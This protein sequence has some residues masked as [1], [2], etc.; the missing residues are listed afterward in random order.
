MV[1]Q[2]DTIAF[3]HATHAIHCDAHNQT[4]GL[5]LATG[6]EALH[7]EKGHDM[8]RKDFIAGYMA[9]LAR[10]GRNKVA[11]DE[12]NNALCKLSH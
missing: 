1:R 9:A 2:A 3:T 12:C 10:P 4:L 8:S 6:A 11:A 5:T 7:V